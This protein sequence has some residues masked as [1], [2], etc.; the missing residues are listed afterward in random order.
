MVAAS[1]RR[2]YDTPVWAQHCGAVALTVVAGLFHAPGVAESEA[3]TP[4]APPQPSAT[5]VIAGGVLTALD[6]V[7]LDG[8]RVSISSVA[9]GESA[10][11]TT[12]ANGHYAFTDLPSGKYRVIASRD[13]YSALAY[14]LPRSM[15]V[16]PS[17]ILTPGE[18]RNAVDFRLA[19]AADIV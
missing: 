8:T 11:A 16:G 9:T 6:G 19:A 18:R 10:V 3:R 2:Y 14:G 17:L 12:G 7:P 4:S 5:G 15:L 13:G 1:V